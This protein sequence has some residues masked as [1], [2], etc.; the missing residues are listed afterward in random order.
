V[1]L[2]TADVNAA[3]QLMGVRQGRGAG[4][5]VSAVEPGSAA[6]AAGVRPG[7]QLLA[8]SDPVR[9]TEMW[10]LNPQASLR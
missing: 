8:V 9:R 7:Q 4:I 3:V 5:L 10:E 6:A 1:E 2:P